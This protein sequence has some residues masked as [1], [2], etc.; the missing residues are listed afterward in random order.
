MDRCPCIYIKGSVFKV[1]RATMILLACVVMLV[2]AC[3]DPESPKPPPIAPDPGPTFANLTEKDHVLNNLVVSYLKRDINEYKRILDVDYYQFFF[4]DGDVSNGLPLEGWDKTQDELAT[5]NLLNR[6]SSAPNRII[7]ID[8]VV[9]QENLI[10]VDV[11]ADAPLTE[12]WWTVTTNYSFTFKT[13]NDI[14]YITSGSPRVQFIVRNIGTDV[15][16]QWRL[17]RW[18]DLGDTYLIRVAAA[19]VEETTWGRVKALYSN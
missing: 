8:L 14:S 4:S 10:W 1:I 5:A 3:S 12:T 9:A 6:N 2:T 17:V 15:A 19:A 18:R 11:A 13:A 16:P 7:A